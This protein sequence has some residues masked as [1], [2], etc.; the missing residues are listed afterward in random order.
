MSGPRQTGLIRSHLV[1][2][3][4]VKQLCIKTKAISLINR[5]VFRF[6]NKKPAMGAGGQMND[7]TTKKELLERVP[8]EKPPFGI[9]DLR[10][11][12]PPHCFKRSFATAFYYLFRD[13]CVNFSLYYIAI[14]YIYHLPQPFSYI[15]WPLYWLIQGSIMVALWVI[16]HDCCH[17]TF[18]NHQ[19]IDDTIGLIIHSYILTPYFAFKY[20]HR[21][22]HANTSSIEKD[23]NWVPKLKKDTWFFEVL[24]NPFGNI[25]ILVLT[26]LVGYPGYF[27]VNLRGRIY[28]GWASHYNPLGP[29]FNDSERAQVLVSNVG[30]FVVLYGLYK[31]GV[32]TGF[33]WLLYIYVYPWMV[34][35]MGVL[36]FTYLNHNHPSVA[37]YDATEWDWMR[38]ALS[39]VDRD[40]G[41]FNTIFHDEPNAHV[42]HHLFSSIPH[43]HIVEATQAIK[44]ILGKYYNYDDSSV[45]K[46][47]FKFTKECL[48]IEEDHEK[49]GVYWYR[50]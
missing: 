18:S 20:S 30:V 2:P 33:Q 45:L 26:F 41:I 50:K 22:H 19:W 8:I 46:T 28:K 44:P 4:N 29:I 34:M 37:H 31:I 47:L 9:A 6:H 11:A 43:Y 25:L 7:T 17:H 36:L 49:K 13:L 27:L 32:K 1:V 21:S 35:G 14:N 15:A 42:V 5:Y 10:K 24:A 39:T 23:E 3:T 16:C 48:Y 38:G 40:Y 12:I